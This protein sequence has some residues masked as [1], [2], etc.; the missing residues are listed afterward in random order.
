MKIQ[1]ICEH[2][3]K[4]VE[5]LPEDNGNHCYVQGKLNEAEMYCDVDIETEI[6]TDIDDIKTMDDVD[7]IETESTL[8]GIRFTCRNCGEYIELTNLT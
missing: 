6:S 7:D 3:G 5:L 1:V 8:N 4:I 2:C